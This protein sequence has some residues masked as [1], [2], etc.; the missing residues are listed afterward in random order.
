MYT[1][2]YL[3]SFDQ[4]PLPNRVVLGLR[5]QVIQVTLVLVQNYLGGLV[6]IVA[7]AR[8]CIYSQNFCEIQTHKG[9]WHAD[10]LACPLNAM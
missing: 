6:Q 7:H 4:L 10:R 8:R 9:S 1:H 5:P 2:V 3:E